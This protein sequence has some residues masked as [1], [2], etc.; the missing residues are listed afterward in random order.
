MLELA[1]NFS[2][3]QTIAEYEAL[4][5]GL[6]DKVLLEFP[7]APDP[8]IMNGAANLPNLAS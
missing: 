1:D 5:T 2:R 8:K 6:L 7:K 3:D 4:L